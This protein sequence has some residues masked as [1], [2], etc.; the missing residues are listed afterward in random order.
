MQ[1][2]PENDEIIEKS[3]FLKGNYKSIVIRTCLI[4][5]KYNPQEFYPMYLSLVNIEMKEKI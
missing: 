5:L 3:Y 1:T 4:N 2:I